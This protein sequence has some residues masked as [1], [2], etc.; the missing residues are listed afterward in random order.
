VERVL[1]AIA[2][3]RTLDIYPESIYSQSATRPLVPWA[4]CRSHEFI[5]DATRLY[6]EDFRGY[7]LKLAISVARE[8]I[9]KRKGI[10]RHG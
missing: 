2:D 3:P 8:E 4:V 6:K 5:K 9:Q 7:L 1:D 10:A